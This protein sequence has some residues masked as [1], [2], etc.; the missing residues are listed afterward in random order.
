EEWK[1]KPFRNKLEKV[2]LK[3]KKFAEKI[4]ISRIKGKLSKHD[5]KLKT[6]KRNIR[7]L[8]KKTKKLDKRF[9]KTRKSLKSI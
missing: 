1:L 4:D 7:S 2:Y 9:R 5:K 3:T 6:F 8:H